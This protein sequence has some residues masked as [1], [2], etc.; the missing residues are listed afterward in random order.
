MELSRPGLWQ[1]EREPRQEARICRGRE[2]PQRPPTTQFAQ[3]KGF[4]GSDTF[5]AKGRV[6]CLPVLCRTV[7]QL[8]EEALESA[9]LFWDPK[10]LFHSSANS[11]TCL[12]LHFP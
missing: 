11:P 12:S 2:S 7:R 5:G 6:S 8:W 9:G 1:D 4:P 10:A 3:D